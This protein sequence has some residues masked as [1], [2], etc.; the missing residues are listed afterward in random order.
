VIYLDCAATSLQKPPCVAQAAAEA[1][2]G[3]AN[4]GR[5]AYGAALDGARVVSCCREQLAALFHVPGGGAQVVFTAG[6][7]DSLNLAINGLFRPGQHVITT[8]MEHNSV[9]RPLYRLEEQGVELTILPADGLGRVSPEALRS[10]IR[11]NTAGMV[12]TH[13]SNLCGNVLPVAA[14]AQ[15][16][17][18]HHGIFVLDAAQTAGS[19]PLD[20][21]EL[22]VDVLC[23]PGHKG[24]LGPQGVGVLALRPGILPRPLRVGGSGVQSYL[25]TQPPQLPTALEAGTLNLPGI[26]GLSAALTW[27]SEQQDSRP[28]RAQRLAEQ[29]YRGVVA[30]PGV[31]CYGDYGDFAQ[32]APVVALNLT[33]VDSGRVADALEQRF[34]IAVRA[35][36][37]CA[38]LAHQTFGTQRQGAVRFSFSSFNRED[39]VEQAVLALKMLEEE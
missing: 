28:T 36:A 13:A 20:M 12:C 32:R 34:G 26:A 23:A 18:Q 17:H 37:H 25:K 2:N 15:I 11:P 19:L 31:Q 38:P 8:A 39:E 24:L 21:E 5:G 35:G 10:A 27:R 16:I 22:G 29:F 9:L 3:M 4:C 7:T 6:A 14:F 33:G 1:I 30:L